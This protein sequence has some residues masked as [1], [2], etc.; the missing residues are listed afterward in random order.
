MSSGIHRREIRQPDM[1]KHAQHAELAL[2]IDE[3]VV[4]YDSKVEVQSSGNSDG[5][6]DVVL[7]DLVY[8][9]HAFR[10]LDEHRMHLVQMG[11]R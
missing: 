9:I 1:L 5:C 3:G 7:F 6:D 4:R 10:D 2:L 8:D 11:L